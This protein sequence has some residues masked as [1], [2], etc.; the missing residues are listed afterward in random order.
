MWGPN[1]PGPGLL[2]PIYEVELEAPNLY[3]Y[4]CVEFSLFHKCQ[5]GYCWAHP[6]GGENKKENAFIG[7][8]WVS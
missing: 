6:A 7:S 3:V 8:I 2:D 4:V 5:P 1:V